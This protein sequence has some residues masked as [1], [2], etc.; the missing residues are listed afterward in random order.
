M[1]TAESLDKCFENKSVLITG[2]T[3]FVGRN[4]LEF[5]IKT[6]SYRSGSLK[7]TCVTRDPNKLYSHWPTEKSKLK[8]LDWDIRKPLNGR[9]LHFDYVFHLAGENRTLKDS[10]QAKTILDTSILGTQNVLQATV[11]ERINAPKIIVASSGAVYETN[12][13]EKLRFR[14]PS[15]ISEKFI[16]VDDPYRSGKSRAETICR[17]FINE[18]TSQI[19][20]ARLFTF[21][22][23]HLPLNANFAIGNFFQDCLVNRPIMVRS[24]GTSV[25]SYQFSTD[26]INWLV[27]ILIHGKNANIYNIGS[28][29]Q[30]SIIDLA[31]RIGDIFDNKFGVRILG[32]QSPD[33]VSSFYVP[34]LEKAEKELS[35]TNFFNLDASLLR[36]RQFLRPHKPTWTS[37][38][39]TS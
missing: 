19:I 36:M 17:R 21:V 25:R 27:T 15:E 8:V 5:L 20:I 24:N 13:D 7:L 22:G 14:E 38:T 31:N 3:G 28:S 33:P 9:Q 10:Q 11:T 12:Q 16:E 1:M 29:E 2:S 39:I 34:K 32:D 4:L 18:S 26:M 30:V 35:L 37:T 6:E 23:P